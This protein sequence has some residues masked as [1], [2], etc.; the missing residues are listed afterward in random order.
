VGRIQFIVLALVCSGLIFFGDSFI[1]MWAGP[2][3]SESYYVALLLMIPVTIPLIQNVGIE[4]Q[5][6][7]DKHRFRSVAY[8][9]MAVV[10]LVLSIFLCQIYGPIGSAFGTAISVLIVNGFVMNIYYYRHCGIDIGA[11]WKSIARLSLGLVFPLIVGVII[12]KF[13]HI[14]RVADLL[15]VIVIYTLVY[16]LSMWVFGLNQEEK[17]M[18]CNR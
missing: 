4:I 15:L 18:V 3:Y 14:G 6:A 7:Q 16:A 11:F 2:E 17:K 10:N 12:R 5:R 9:I 1:L 8:I 13:Y